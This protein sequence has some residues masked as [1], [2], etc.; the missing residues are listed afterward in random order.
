[1]ESGSLSSQD[2]AEY[3]SKDVV[4]YLHVTSRIPGNTTDAIFRNYG[5]TGFPTL[6]FLDADGGKLAKVAGADRSVE[7]FKKTE[8]QIAELLELRTAAAKGDKGADVDL[9]LMELERGLLSFE[10]AKEKRGSLVTP[11]KSNAEFEDKVARIDGHLFEFEITTLVRS[12]GP[13]TEKRKQVAATLYEM[14]KNGR[15]PAKF[16]YSFW[17]PVMEEAKSQGDATIFEK[18]LNAFREQYGDHPRFESRF[19][20]MEADLQA[21]QSGS[22][23]TAQVEVPKSQAVVLAVTGM[24]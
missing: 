18:G 11:K 8:E 4:P 16:N 22:G 6:L 19:K 14:A 3:A 13:A 24:R 10:L 15:F 21:L 12:A 23:A 7:G 5:G 1:M 20:K 2:F 9:L 17:T